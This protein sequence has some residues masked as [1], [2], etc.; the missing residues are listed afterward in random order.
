MFT[1]CVQSP[2]VLVEQRCEISACTLHERG[3]PSWVVV[4]KGRDVVHSAIVY[5]P[6][7][8]L[9]VVQLDFSLHAEQTPQGRAQN[10][11]DTVRSSVIHELLVA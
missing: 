2:V 11:A 1:A 10:L 6:C 3:Q 4:Q 7:I 9:C 8:V 5:A